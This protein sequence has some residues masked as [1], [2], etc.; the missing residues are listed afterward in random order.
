[1][2]YRFDPEFEDFVSYN[3]IGLPL[4]FLVAESL[5]KPNEMAKGMIEE[6]FNL[7]LASLGVEDTGFETLDDVFVG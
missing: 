6:S 1:M 2:N 5:V 4:S 3:D 7:F